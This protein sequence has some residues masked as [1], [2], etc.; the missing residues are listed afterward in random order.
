MDEYD[1]NEP[2]P[3][4][5][6]DDEQVGL[7]EAE[8]LARDFLPR[9]E[10]T[11]GGGGRATPPVTRSRGALP[12][13]P[14][15]VESQSSSP[16]P[17]RYDA[18]RN[19]SCKTLQDH[20]DRGAQ[21]HDVIIARKPFQQTVDSISRIASGRWLNDLA[22][23]GFFKMV[24]DAGG[25]TL[26][27]LSSFSSNV[28]DPTRLLAS[29]LRPERRDVV[30]TII[31]PLHVSHHWV[32]VVVGLKRQESAEPCI[33][34]VYDSLA[35]MVE[36]NHSGEVKVLR[37]ALANVLGRERWKIEF[38]PCLRQENNDDCGVHACVNVLRHLGGANMMDPLDPVTVRRELITALFSGVPDLPSAAPLCRRAL[39]VHPARTVTPPQVLVFEAGFSK[40]VAGLHGVPILME[41]SAV[42]KFRHPTL[43]ETKAIRDGLTPPT[44]KAHIR[45]F[46]LLKA[47]VLSH[48]RAGSQKLPIAILEA[49]DH[50]ARALKWTPGTALKQLSN[51][52]SFFARLDQY[53]DQTPMDF[54]KTKLLA[55][56]LR[57][58][59]KQANRDLLRPRPR[60][61]TSQLKEILQRERRPQ[62][63][64]LL[65]LCWATAARPTNVLRLRAANLKFG[66]SS[67]IVLWTDHKT[68]ERM[69]P[70]SVPSGLGPYE[71]EIRTWAEG[72]GG[73]NLLFP[74]AELPAGLLRTLKALRSTLPAG[75]D[76][77]AL[78][79]G[80]LTELAAVLT[81]AELLA[82][83]GHAS[84][85]SLRRYLRWGAA[86]GKVAATIRLG[87]EKVLWE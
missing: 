54:S 47:Y 4:D 28:A 1:D 9:A 23:N 56:S 44:R 42:L 52:L 43:P 46:L 7:L 14:I 84:V 17:V 33:I 80:S 70:Y 19:Q 48:P 5:D 73:T 16:A 8:F 26:W 67:F 13:E 79:R 61:T 24:K 35:P 29:N 32:C 50:Y 27:M 82:V 39:A 20:I 63:R 2:D 51:S 74:E 21:Q 25:Q 75:M 31:M 68:V 38:P 69:G 57:F 77:R 30:D 65:I 78:R 71:E 18:D 66:P 49:T 11:G 62:V 45:A 36:D 64:A 40:D 87:A 41:A 60:L 15:Q 86:L 6:D 12:Q 53:V 37:D 83:S 59:Q 10:Q 72:V 34:Q 85:K 81:E 76:L 55:D 3:A 22:M 58:Y